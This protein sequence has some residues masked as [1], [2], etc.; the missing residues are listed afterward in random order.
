MKLNPET[1][2]NS[3]ENEGL[4]KPGSSDVS[5]KTL[6]KSDISSLSEN[7][8]RGVCFDYE[9]MDPNMTRL[10]TRM[11]ILIC[12]L[13][14]DGTTLYANDALESI[15]GY[16]LAEIQ[17]KN[18]WEVLFP[19]KL[20]EKTEDFRKR[21]RSEDVSNY[22]LELQ[23]KDG[24]TATILWD[25]MNY[26]NEDGSLETVVGIGV[27][28]TVRKEMERKLQ[29]AI[30]QDEFTGMVNRGLF[31]DRLM[32]SFKRLKRKKD[33]IFAVLFIN[34]DNFSRVNDLFSYS[35][36]DK[37][38]SSL[39]QRIKDCLRA[40]DTVGHV[41]RDEFIVLLED[42]RQISDATRVAN[43]IQQVT[44]VPFLINDHKITINVSIG[45]AVSETEYEKPEHFI[46]D[47]EVAMNR[48]KSMG[49]GRSLMFDTSM[50]EVAQARLKLEGD[51]HRA[52]KNEEFENYYQPIIDLQSGKILGFETLVR[53]HHPEDGFVSP[54]KFIPVAEETRLIIPLGKL[55]MRNACKQVSH[56]HR[57]ILS[58]NDDKIWV[59]VN[60]SAMQFS[61][62]G[63]LKEIEEFLREYQ[64]DGHNFRME[65]T[66]T[67]WMEDPEFARVTLMEMKKLLGITLYIDDFGVGYSSLSYLH[68]LPFDT[69]KIDRSFVTGMESNREKYEIV[70]TIVN[71]AHTLN[72]NVI[73]EGVETRQQM[74]LLRDLGCE[75]GQG[76][77]FSRPVDSKKAEHMILTPPQWT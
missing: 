60:F 63:L 56:W 23:K 40:V 8:P 46:R 15:T 26:Y 73:A 9:H 17:G 58:K 38:L 3:P 55:V 48:A 12:E 14:P 22:E 2:D 20:A 19:D 41:G 39:A 71:L 36:G 31:M 67:T 62:P 5:K 21:I 64:L 53:W 6:P 24:S 34:V 13:H 61:Q 10:M 25:T 42:I 76:Y 54:A 77:Y 29:R 65:I 30:H 59:S 57:N 75:Y 32:Q 51:L 47:A 43:R 27:D 11:P 52:I 33:Y 68:L 37:L 72:R 28:I 1:P 44:S 18:W 70:R 16:K 66:E 7:I 50:Q 49:G 4:K 69:L 35:V 74:E 45:I